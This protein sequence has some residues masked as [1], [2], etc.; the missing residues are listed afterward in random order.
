MRALYEA[1]ESKYMN[2]WVKIE[3]SDEDINASYDFARKKAAAKL[4]EAIYKMDGCQ[5]VD[6]SVTGI[7]AEYA[8]QTYLKNKI[9]IE[10]FVDTRIGI[11]KDFDIPDIPQLNMGIKAV[12]RGKIP[13]VPIRKHNLYPQIICVVDKKTEIRPIV[14]IC[15][16][17]SPDVLDTYQSDELIL[18]PNL[19][20][21]A[22]K[23]GFYGFKYLNSIETLSI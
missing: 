4:G 20:A 23:S 2:T 14:Y 5:L 22:V 19:R 15:G 17:A 16:I 13:V 10:D 1:Y 8:V 7:M 18:D 9:D 12:E 21:R 11:S 6:R 3:M